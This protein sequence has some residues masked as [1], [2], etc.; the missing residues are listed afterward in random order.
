MTAVAVWGSGRTEASVELAAL[1][2]LR[3]PP[4]LGTLDVTLPA[5]ATG[6]E[7]DTANLVLN[8]ALDGL[9]WSSS[10]PTDV[11][12][13]GVAGA[14]DVTF[15]QAGPRTLRVEA[16]SDDGGLTVRSVRLRVDDVLAR[17]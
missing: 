12:V 11:V 15:G 16:R 13:P 9:V 1:L 14:A 10:D 3:D 2:P 4:N 17:P 6:Y 8:T 5:G 7:G